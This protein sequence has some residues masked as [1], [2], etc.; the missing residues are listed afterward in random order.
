MED[1]MNYI[2]TLCGYVYKNAVGDTENGIAP[3]TDFEDISEDWTC[4][5]CGASKEDFEPT[6]ADELE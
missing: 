3:G 4:P 6:D 1:F 5:L 2:C